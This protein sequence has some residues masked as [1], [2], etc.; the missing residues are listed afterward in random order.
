MAQKQ[1]VT[2]KSKDKHGEHM[3]IG[4]IIHVWFIT[5]CRSYMSDL[6]NKTKT[7]TNT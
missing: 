3:T 4:D 7:L 1:E 2:Q 6:K 5:M